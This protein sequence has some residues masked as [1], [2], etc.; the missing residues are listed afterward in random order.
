VTLLR[1]WSSSFVGRRSGAAT[2]AREA[3]VAA[4]AGCGQEALAEPGARSH[5]DD[6]RALDRLGVVQFLRLVRLEREQAVPL[7]HEVVDQADHRDAERPLQRVAVDLPPL[8]HVGEA[9]LVVEDAAR[10]GEAAGLDRQP[11]GLALG[12]RQ[13]LLAHRL[14]RRVALIEV[15]L[16]V[17][18]LT[19]RLVPEHDLGVDGHA[20]EL[21]SRIGAAAVARHYEDLPSDVR[22][23]RRLAR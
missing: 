16:C 3:G 13:E 12:L 10:A 15:L 21:Q 23:R 2:L 20:E 17:D 14:E 7:R 4:V 18:E 22:R 6:G 1:T 11:P 5:A 8:R 9:D 19:G